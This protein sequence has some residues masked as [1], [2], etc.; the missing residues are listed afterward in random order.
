MREDDAMKVYIVADVE[1]VAGVV[2][3]EHRHAAM[4][5]LNFDVLLR[6]R[7]LLTEE[8][9]AAARGA[10]NAGATRV[11]AHDHHGLGYTI[12]PDMIDERLELIHGR[13]EHT[14]TMDR[15][16]P[17]LDGD[18]AAL[19]LIGMHAKAGTDP[20]CTPHSLIHVETDQGKTY[21]LSEAAMSMAFAGDVGVPAV[22]LA[23]D[24]ATIADARQST[25]CDCETVTTKTHYGAQ[26]ART[27]A[28]A[29]SRQ[30]IE[31]G[32]EKAINRRK[33][34]RPFKIDGPCRVRIAD[35]NPNA[36]W[37]KDPNTKDTFTAAIMDT[38]RTVP[39][40]KPIEQIDDGWRYPD[41][42]QPDDDNSPQNR[43][44]QV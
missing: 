41:R 3:Y 36:L 29:R 20:G 2:F 39:W 19:V 6:N 4:S 35:R 12:L 44:N 42:P 34:I 7:Q 38:F 1:A 43:W 37:P 33:D 21:E 27:I 9:N 23:G 32:V 14:V 13:N 17:E 30:L 10:F 26:L 8:V 24:E 40:Y 22:F 28:P 16:H 5:P 15:R 31:A 18:T 25:G 11:I